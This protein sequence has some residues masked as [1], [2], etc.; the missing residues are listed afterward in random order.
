MF[1]ISMTQGVG[2]LGATILLIILITWSNNIARDMRLLPGIGRG[3]NGWLIVDGQEVV[4]GRAS[5]R[6]WPGMG[7][8][9]WYWKMSLVSGPGKGLLPGFMFRCSPFRGDFA[10]P[11]AS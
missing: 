2:L 3:Q 9:S 8:M 1:R 5:G 10:V 6:M 7:E 11:P 4:A